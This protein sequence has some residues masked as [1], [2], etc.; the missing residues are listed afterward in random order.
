MARAKAWYKDKLGLVP[1]REDPLGA[2]YQLAG[3]TAFL[4]YPTMAAGQAPNTLMTFESRDVPA[5][6][7]AL[8]AR[9]VK[10]EDYDMPGLK[11]EDGI[12]TLPG[13]IG[14][15]DFRGGWFKDS[16]GNILAI[17]STPY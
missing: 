4:L 8:K 16:E 12:A 13:G 14:G 7:A 3:G 9:G 17:G 10:F 1:D 15:M 6:V 2:T 5:D 11:T